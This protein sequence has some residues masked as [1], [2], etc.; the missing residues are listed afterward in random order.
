MCMDASSRRKQFNNSRTSFVEGNTVRKLSV[1]P[2]IRRE[3]YEQPSPRR[4]EQRHP[5]TLSSMNFTSLLVLTVAIITTLY[6]SVEYLKMQSS[7]HTMEKKI[8]KLEKTL[9]AMKN[10]NDAK[11]TQIDEAYD[12]AYVYNVAVE[13]LGMV[14]PNKNDVVTYK[15]SADD[16]VIQFEDIPK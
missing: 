4:Q 15:S 14:Y 11:Y 13:E 5:K 2:D 3:G 1:A 16:Y 7:V 8:I 12:L 9:T 10:E 6:V